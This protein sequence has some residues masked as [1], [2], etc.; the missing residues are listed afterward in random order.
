MAGQYDARSG[1]VHLE[2]QR[3]IRRPIGYDMV[4]MEGAF[5]PARRRL[6]GKI[7]SFNCGAFQLAAPGV[8]LA[9][10]PPA[11]PAV[12]PPERRRCP[13]NVTEYAGN[14]FEYWDSSLSDAPGA[15]REAEPIDDVIDWLKKQNFSCMGTRRVF[16]DASGTKGSADDMVSVRER[17]V[18][19]CDGDC[20]SVRYTPYVGAMIFHFGLSQPVPVLEKASG[21]AAPNSAGTSRAR[22]VPGRYP[23]SL[24][25]DGPPA[26][27]TAAVTARLRKPTTNRPE[28]KFRKFRTVSRNTIQ[29]GRLKGLL[30]RHVRLAQSFI[31]LLLAFAASAPA[32]INIGAPVNAGSRI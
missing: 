31:F 22:P 8:A 14:G 17:F 32:P 3:W 28:K 23:T 16:R 29:R 25:I 20:R 24:S 4:G 10:S 21:L 2:P 1:R 13:S 26:D 5:D 7:T 6:N 18:I 9:Q 30:M 12:L 19:E 15:A 11:A 27:S